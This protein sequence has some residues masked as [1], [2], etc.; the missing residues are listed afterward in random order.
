[1]DHTLEVFHLEIHAFRNPN[2]QK[3]YISGIQEFRSKIQEL[4]NPG[5]QESEIQEL[6]TAEIQEFRNQESMH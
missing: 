4:R 1:M 6:R 2:F 5:I 3:T